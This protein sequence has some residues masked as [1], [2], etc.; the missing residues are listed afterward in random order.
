MKEDIL[1]LFLILMGKLPVFLLGR[2][3]FI[4]LLPGIWFHQI[5]KIWGHYFFK[6]FFFFLS[7]LFFRDLIIG[8]LGHWKFPTSTDILFIFVFFSHI[9]FWIVS[10]NIFSS[11]LMFSSVV[12]DLLLILESSFSIADILSLGKNSI[13]IFLYS[14]C[15]SLHVNVFL[16]FFK[17]VK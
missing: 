9:S 1:S 11:S 6:F 13:C 16:F 12:F 17:H 15:P 2:I 5:W 14:L 10:I 8:I 4:F 3:F 7:F